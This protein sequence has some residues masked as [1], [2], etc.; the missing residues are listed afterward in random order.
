MART[1]KI[2]RKKGPSPTDKHVGSRVRMRRMMLEMSQTKLGD[3]LGVTFQQIQKYETG[4]N[5]IGA[6]RLQEI[7]RIFEVPVAFF[8]Q[9]ASAQES[10]ETAVPAH[11]YVDEFLATR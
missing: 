1:V 3:M 7:A 9:G 2:G 5:R 6:G 10:G 4:K 8:Y 11:T